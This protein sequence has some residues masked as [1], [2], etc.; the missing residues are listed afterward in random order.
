MREDT[1]TYMFSIKSFIHISYEFYYNST[2]NCQTVIVN[3]RAKRRIREKWLKDGNQWTHTIIKYF[4]YN[5]IKK[6]QLI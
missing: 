5:G 2:Q 6:T 4:F 1:C 3:V